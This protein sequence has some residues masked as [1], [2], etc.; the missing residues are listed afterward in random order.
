MTG[1]DTALDAPRSAGEFRLPS[2]GWAFVA[3]AVVLVIATWPSLHLEIQLVPGLVVTGSWSTPG[4]LLFLLERVSTVLL[5]AAILFRAPTAWQTHR[6]L[7]LGAMLLALWTTGNAVWLAVFSAVSDPEFL[8]WSGVWIRA[9][10]AVDLAGIALVGIGLL[11]LRTAA[12][13]G[14]AYA[15]TAATIVLLALPTLVLP[16]IG[17]RPDLEEL[18][19]ELASA[20]VIGW[21]LSV[22]LGAVLDR[23]SPSRFWVPLALVSISQILIAVWQA[24]ALLVAHNQETFSAFPPFYGLMLA[25]GAVV[26]LVVFARELPVGGEQ[27]AG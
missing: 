14:T 24:A 17:F 4:V 16:V 6:L 1:T 21:A 19:F 27:A 5:P 15:A 18:S 12:R 10:Y 26:T 25:A 2:T 9:F 13:S 23:L 7:L 3:L 8:L 20:G 11:G 22:P